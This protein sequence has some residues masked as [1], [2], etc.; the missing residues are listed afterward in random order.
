MSLSC[1]SC[2]TEHLPHCGVWFWC[3]TE[4]PGKNRREIWEILGW[5]GTWI[6]LEC[7]SPYCTLVHWVAPHACV[8]FRISCVDIQKFYMV[9]KVVHKRSVNL[10]KCCTISDCF[11]CHWSQHVSLPFVRTIARCSESSIEWPSKTE[12]ENGGVGFVHSWIPSAGCHGRL[13]STERRECHVLLH[14]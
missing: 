4:D 12:R 11:L 6:H 1:I 14:C 3:L 9:T 8:S 7:I 5:R 13:Q 2:I 10:L